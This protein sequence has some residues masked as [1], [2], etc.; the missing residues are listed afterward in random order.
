M[1]CSRSHRIR[2]FSFYINCKDVF[3]LSKM[4]DLLSSLKNYTKSDIYESSR[5]LG[6][7]LIR[8]QSTTPYHL[9]STQAF[10]MDTTFDRVQVYKQRR[11]ALHNI[12]VCCSLKLTTLYATPPKMLLV[13]GENLRKIYASWC[14]FPALKDCCR[15]IN[16][17]VKRNF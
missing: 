17:F 9:P 15:F 16:S 5:Y 12:S 11:Y 8:N 7:G 3:M 1:T 2:I 6:Y 4:W 10:Q 13:C 14:S